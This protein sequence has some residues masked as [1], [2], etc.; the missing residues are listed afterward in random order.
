MIII[1]TFVITYDKSVRFVIYCT[2]L[3]VEKGDSTKNRHLDPICEKWGIY[4]KTL[5][6]K[7]KVLED[8]LVK[9]NSVEERIRRDRPP[10]RTS[11]AERK[12]KVNEWNKQATRQVPLIHP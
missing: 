2:V 5:S 9:T 11:Q 8:N 1:S 4:Q 10:A 12:K 6:T 7:V 3:F